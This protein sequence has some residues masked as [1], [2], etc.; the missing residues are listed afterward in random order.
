MI[1]EFAAHIGSASLAT[2]TENATSTATGTTA[3][4]QPPSVSWTLVMLFGIVALAI[5]AV[6]WLFTR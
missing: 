6:V 4:A 5:V 3:A 1:S 2:A